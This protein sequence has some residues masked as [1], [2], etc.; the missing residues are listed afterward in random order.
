MIGLRERLMTKVVK[1]PSGCW[2]FKGA[3]DINGYGR[4][5]TG[6]QTHLVHR[7]SWEINIGPI[8]VGKLICHR[9]DN[10]SCINPEHL[11]IGDYTDNTQDMMQKGRRLSTRGEDSPTAKF[12]EADV[13]Y[14]KAEL[15]AGTKRVV[16]AQRFNVS[17]GAID[18]IKHGRNW[19]WVP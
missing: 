13:S 17:L 9:C 1:Q 11:F 10:P 18:G 14:I 12:T 19:G 8:P 2:E 16:L 7:V 6:E 15:C 4:I 3:K 5:W